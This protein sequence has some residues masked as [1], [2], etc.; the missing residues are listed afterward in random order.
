LS[1]TDSPLLVVGDLGREV[2]AVGSEVV[3]AREGAFKALGHVL[4]WVP[5]NGLHDTMF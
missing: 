1:A 2:L 3:V 5:G 4:V